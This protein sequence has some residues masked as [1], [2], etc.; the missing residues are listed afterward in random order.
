MSIR[1]KLKKEE[2]KKKG[3]VTNKINTLTDN[4]S[5]RKIKTNPQKIVPKTEINTLTDNEI[6]GQLKNK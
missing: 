2:N 6:Q 1:D 5:G 3:K 4:E